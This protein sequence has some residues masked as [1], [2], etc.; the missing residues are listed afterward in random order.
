[1]LEKLKNDY[2]R[3]D[4]KFNVLRIMFIY[5]LGN[6]LYYSDIPN[7]L[8]RI[9][10][11]IVYWLQIIFV[12]IPYRIEM[13]FK[14][15]IGEGLRLV[16][17]DG[18]IIHANVEIGKNCTIFQQVT[19]GANEHILNYSDVAKIGN[20][21]YIGAGAKIIGNIN[22]GNDVKI[23]ANAVVTKDIDNGYTVTCEQVAR[24]T[25]NTTNKRTGII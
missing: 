11:K 4:K 20:N 7:I 10:C 6:K 22:I 16:H 25:M 23:G 21:V 14:A 15:K 18:I 12:I 8:K 9:C 2:I 3:S 1:M 24:K 19:I 17:L 13:P 5:R